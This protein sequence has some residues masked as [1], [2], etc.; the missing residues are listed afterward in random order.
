[1]YTIGNEEV[2]AVRRVAERK[3]TFRYGDPASGHG[4]E[5]VHFEEEWANHIGV[6]H[7]L[8]TTSGT[9]SLIC[10]LAAFGIG[11]GDE[12][13]VPGYTYIATAL[14]VTN[15]G[16][17]PVIVDIDESCTMDPS[18]LEAAIGPRTRAVIP[19]HMQGMPCDLGRILAIA[20]KHDLL[21]AED[22][23]QAV[24]GSYQGK[25]LGTW[26]DA[27]AFSFNHYK[28]LSAGESGAFVTSKASYYERA[29]IQ[30]DGG[31]SLWPEVVGMTED[32]F[33][34]GNFRSNEFAAA[35]LRE[36][37]K[38]LPGILDH[39]S[40]SKRAFVSG[41]SLP[42]S[43]RIAPVHDLDGDCGVQ[44]LL[45][46]ESPDVCRRA[47]E[48]LNNAGV[49]AV[50]PADSNR[51]IYANW[52]PIMNRRG[53]HHPALDPFRM[54]ENAEC[55]SSYAPDML[56]QTLSVLDRSIMIMHSTDWD[57]SER[58][59]MVEVTSRVLRTV[60]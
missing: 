46:A 38:R 10:A 60:G 53:A 26:G 57:A 21:V 54:A 29:F 36:Q 3:Q 22:A 6:P 23:C 37:L 17:I 59:R 43:I 9:A 27:G 41:L 4:N 25:H 34:G 5:V 1:M 16:A 44:T 32:I 39:L 8:A 33:G 7:V 51:H 35:I 42:D 19:V 47:L 50:T 58:D 24:G 56:P 13:I 52:Q 15:V 14:A 49:P 48:A 2:E 30:H 45:T 28:I 31:C 40:A 11:P 20:K 12:V 18:A 55:R